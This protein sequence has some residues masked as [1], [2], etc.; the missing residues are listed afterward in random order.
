[1]W[2]RRH[3][4]PAPARLDNGR[5]RYSEEQVE[6]VQEVAAARAAGLGLAAAIAQ[7]QHRPRCAEVSVFAALRRRY[8]ELAVELIGKP[9]LVALSHAIEDECLARAERAVLFGAFQRRAFYRQAQPRWI[10]LAREARL[11]AVFADFHQFRHPR[12]GPLEVPLS[13]NH[14]LSREWVIVCDTE[15]SGACLAGREPAASSAES[16]SERRSFEVFWSVEPRVVRSA[17]RVCAGLAAD[18]VGA[19]MS[20]VRGLL[21]REPGAPTGAQLRLATAVMA[22]TLRYA[23]AGQRADTAR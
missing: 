12:E 15:A 2:E 4:F 6:Q 22:R 19:E 17:A 3:G 5:R 23:S 14:P 7:A 9:W 20:G 11:A 16:P 13:R 18:Q 8:P 1:M 10:E 21:E